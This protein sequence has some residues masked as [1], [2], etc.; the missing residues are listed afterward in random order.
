MKKKIFGIFLV[1]LFVFSGF[2]SATINIDDTQEIIESPKPV[3]KIIVI[4]LM[5]R[6]DNTETTI[7]YEVLAFALFIEGGVQ[8]L[9][10][11]EMVRLY[12]PAIILDFFNLVIGFCEDW[13]IIG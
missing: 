11:G 6:M 1:M 4:G 12:S 9:N 3:S 13:S 2:A 5:E 10:E 8:R 7:D